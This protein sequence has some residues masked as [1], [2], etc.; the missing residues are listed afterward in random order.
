MSSSLPLI[1]HFFSFTPSVFTIL[2]AKK[3]EATC[4]V[5]KVRGLLPHIEEKD[6]DTDV[7][8]LVFTVG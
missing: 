6:I 2:F 7:S 1:A 3:K 4:F 5:T 8:L